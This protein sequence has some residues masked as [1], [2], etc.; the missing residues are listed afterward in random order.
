MKSKWILVVGG[1]LGLALLA[2]AIFVQLGGNG[3]G[4]Q[5][6]VSPT[7][8]PS[9]YGPGGEETPT[10]TDSP[11]ATP[12]EAKLSLDEVGFPMTVV[13]GSDYTNADV[14]MVMAAKEWVSAVYHLDFSMKYPG[15]D[16]D[17]V[18]QYSGGD[19]REEYLSNQKYDQNPRSSDVAANEEYNKRAGGTFKQEVTFNE[20]WLNTVETLVIIDI[21]TTNQLHEQELIEQSI[22]MKM[23]T[24]DTNEYGWCVVDDTNLAG[25]G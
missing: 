11:S 14:K 18:I 22:Y 5:S 4:P 23:N 21:T 7:T 16:A 10:E 12:N 24:C 8:K 15:F 2:W 1:V 13:T 17:K 25:D 19:L 20:G 3:T 9:S 6:T